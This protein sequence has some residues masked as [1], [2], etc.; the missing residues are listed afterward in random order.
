MHR[1]NSLAI[2]SLIIIVGLIQASAFDYISILGAKPD[3]LLCL[4]VFFSLFSFTSDSVKAAL[5]AGLL[6]DITSSSIFGGYTISFLLIALLLNYNR[7]KFF[8]EKPS[9]QIAIVSVSYLTVSLLAL[10]FNL[11]SH[12]MPLPH[13]PFLKVAIV[14]AAYAGL[15]SPPIFFVL[16]KVFKVGIAASA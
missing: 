1:I 14:G 9:A 16:S 6:E 7:Y 2:F 12:N 5:T 4:V 10:S 13:H 15:I 11:I 8:K 3:L